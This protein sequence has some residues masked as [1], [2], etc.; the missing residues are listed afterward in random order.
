[1]RVLQLIPSLEVGGAERVV[2]LLTRALVADGHEV[3]VVSFAPRVD[4]WLT[5]ELEG[6]PLFFLDKKPG[7]D[8]RVIPRLARVLRRFRPQVVHNHLHLLKYLL[9]ARAAWRC[10]VVHTVHNLAEQEASGPDRRVQWL[11]FRRGVTPVAIGDAVA[12]S[13]QA[14]YGVRAPIVPNGIDVKSF[15][16]PPEVRGQLR[17]SLGV[18]DDMPVVLSAGRLNE[19]KDPLTL[20]RAVEGLEAELWLAGEGPLR[21]DIE[22]LASPQVR[23][24]GLRD[25]VPRLMAAADVFAMSSRWEGNPLAVMEAMAAGLPVVST[26]VGC[27]P[28]LV[29]PSTGRVV[30]LGEPTQLRSAIQEL[31]EDLPRARALGEAGSQAALQRFDVSVMARGYARLYE[32]RAACS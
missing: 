19:Q 23:L 2:T 3:G 8:P 27:V 20:V 13:I 10:P 4:S 16:L 30:E 31:I 25:D 15:R 9:P 6:L 21:G 24:L 29:S 17:A 11:A 18:A 14:L 7:L 22:A 5:R 26:G 32:E 12:A 1:M 28:E